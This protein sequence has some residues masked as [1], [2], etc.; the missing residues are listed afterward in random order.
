MTYEIKITKTEPNPEYKEQLKA[1]NS[2]RGWS[3]R[4]SIQ[5]VAKFIRDVLTCELT[6]DQ[7]KA[8]KKSVLEVFI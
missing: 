4:D 7:F 6:E 3:S 5:P 8:V 2:D 1:Y